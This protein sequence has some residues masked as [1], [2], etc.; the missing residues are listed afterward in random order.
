MREPDIRRVIGRD[1]RPRLVDQIFGL[2]PLPVVKEFRLVGQML[3]VILDV[4]PLEPVRRVVRRSAAFED[5]KGL[6]HGWKHTKHNPNW[7]AAW[8]LIS[9]PEPLMAGMIH[10]IALKDVT[11]AIQQPTD[12]YD[13]MLEAMPHR[14]LAYAEQSSKLTPVT[15]SR[16]F[17]AAHSFGDVLLRF[18]N[19]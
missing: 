11:M 15:P 4:H 13:G 9:L 8:R 17:N 3:E 5:G 1:D 16:W 14:P 19:D 10:P 12:L 7:E 18:S 2:D 6:W